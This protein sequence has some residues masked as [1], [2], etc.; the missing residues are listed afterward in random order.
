M[1]LVVWLYCRSNW[2]GVLIN[3]YFFCILHIISFETFLL[4]FFG[5]AFRKLRPKSLL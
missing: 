4:S 2:T 1:G 5:F 3:D